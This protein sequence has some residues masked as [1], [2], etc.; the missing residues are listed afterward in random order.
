MVVDQI[1]QQFLA[2]G[3]EKY[4]NLVKPHQEQTISIIPE[5]SNYNDKGD[6]K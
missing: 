1:Q 5:K 2:E 3:L 6:S 4:E